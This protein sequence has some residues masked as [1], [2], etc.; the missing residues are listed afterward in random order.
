[1]SKYTDEAKRLANQPYTTIVFRDMTTDGEY[2]YVA[3][4]PDLPGCVSDG[5]SPQE[6]INNLLDARILYIETSLEDSLAIPKPHILTKNIQIE[7][8]MREL[9]GDEINAIP[10]DIKHPNNSQSAS[11]ISQFDGS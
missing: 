11:L 1:M 7:I 6:A 4:N 2:G 9:L 3:I 8:D 10:E 5:D